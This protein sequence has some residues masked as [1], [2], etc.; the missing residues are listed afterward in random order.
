[1]AKAF[2]LIHKISNKEEES[3]IPFAD[4]DSRSS[5]GVPPQKKRP[6]LEMAFFYIL[7][8]VVF[9]IMGATFLSP[10]MFAG[11]FNRQGIPSPQ[12]SASG[13]QQGF[14]IEKDG[15]SVDETRKELGLSSPVPVV[16]PSPVAE[17]TSSEPVVAASKAAK[18]QILNGTNKTGA[19]DG[20]RKK[21]AAKGIV[22]ASI[23]NHGNRNVTKTIVYY[24]AAYK[25][26]AEQ[27]Q[28]VVGGSL[29]MSESATGQ[30]DIL[31]IIG[32]N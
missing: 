25:T 24:D 17:T 29:A 1:M 9:F 15:Q 14:T 2:D 18:I 13:P 30:Y 23:G 22:V 32:Q 19:A 3:R 12:P 26:A 6:R 28:R 21:L 27:V 20:L 8:F 4:E 11:L 10:N 31:V 5:G 7:L 16:A